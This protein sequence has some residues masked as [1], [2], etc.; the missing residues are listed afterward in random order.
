MMLNTGH[1]FNDNQLNRIESISNLRVDIAPRS[2][3]FFQKRSQSM[4]PELSPKTLEH[5]DSFRLTLNAYNQTF[6]LY[7]KPNFELFPPQAVMHYTGDENDQPIQQEKVL[8]Y[9]GHTVRSPEMDNRWMQE[10]ADVL[11]LGSEF[12]ATTT[13]LGWARILVRHDLMSRHKTD[14]PI[15]EGAFKVQNDI[16]HIKATT[17]YN[18]VKRSV[19]ITAS[20]SD[21]M[22]IYR[23]SDTQQ[24]QGHETS[25]AHAC[26]FDNL[27]HRSIAKRGEVSRDAFTKLTGQGCPTTKKINY[28]GAAADCTYVQYYRSVDNARTQ[29]I[30]N[31]NIASAVFEETFNISL[32]L[33]NITIMDRA[34]PQRIDPE[35]AWNRACD[36]NY[37]LGNRLS[38]FSLWRSKMKNDGAG[39]WHLMTN[40]ATGVEVG[41][42]WLKQLCNTE[43][44]AQANADGKKQFVSGAGI[45]AITRDEWKVVAHE[46]GHGF[47]AIHDCVADNCP[48]TGSDCKCCQ[49]NSNQCDSSGFL[50]SALSNTSAESFSPCSINTICDAFPSIG[51]CLVDPSDNRHH[52]YRLN[53]CGN[54]IKEEGEEC[55]PG[56]VDT[57][58][59]DAKT[60]KLKPTAVCEDTNEGCCRQCQIRP[61]NDLC[62]PASNP[63]DIAEYCSGTSAECPVD[64]SMRDGTSCGPGGL[65]CASGQCTSRDEQCLSRGYVL[66]ITRSCIKNNEE[67]KLLCNSPDSEKCLIF[68]GNFI[69]GTPCGFGGRCFAGECHNGD[70]IGSSMLYLSDHKGVAIPVGIIVFLV[71][72]A[73]GFVLFWF[74]CWRCTGY[75]EKR[76]RRRSRK[77]TST[78]SI[79]P[80]YYS[81]SSSSSQDL[82]GY[83]EPL[84]EL[85]PAPKLSGKEKHSLDFMTPPPYITINAAGQQQQK[86]KHHSNGSTSPSPSSSSSS[87]SL[88]TIVNTE[89]KM[90]TEKNE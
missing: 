7:L 29:I 2:R 72:C 30:N 4:N 26:G 33:I 53:V 6:Y 22:V 63:C 44:H 35:M 69:D 19:D 74:G 85:T 51:S 83:N 25:Q 61:K 41:L 10:N 71:V 1:S 5:D 82:P 62:R 50:M 64:T 68:S 75:R 18:L 52:V 55:D 28:M 56:G 70:A 89:D 84:Q 65:K 16:Y 31:F 34:C 57:D 27:L 21:V 78:N 79:S 3:H 45:S 15:I 17:N 58:C 37:S 73:L 86:E 12:D 11:K 87:S 88:A 76:N 80:A 54:G 81:D 9:K 32:G 46:I 40:C 8:V 43:A 90:K 47:G 23:D 42:A 48:C 36:A 60:C 39:L 66:N 14:Q 77:S 49:L 38:D 67:C 20:D 24:H 59:C 13:Q